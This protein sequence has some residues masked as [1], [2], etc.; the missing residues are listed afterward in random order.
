MPQPLFRAEVIEARRQRWLGPVVLD[1][2]PLL[3][4]L[5]ALVVAALLLGLGFAATADYSR[6]TR[7]AGVLV[8]DRGLV[9]VLAPAA[10]VVEGVEADEGDP[11]AAGRVLVRLAAP[12]ASDLA[13]DALSAADAGLDER[14]RAAREQQAAQEAL[15]QVRLDSVH[16]Q[17]AQITD[18]RMRLAAEH[19]ARAGQRAL[20][21]ESLARLE[22][23]ASSSGRKR[24][25][26]AVTREVAAFLQNTPAICRASYIAPCLYALF[27]RGKLGAM[28]VAI[29]ET[30]GLRQ[31]EARLSGVLAAAG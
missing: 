16:A 1:T 10:G 27:D 3:R 2:P 18:E 25:M 5:L 30:R 22:P 19:A 23:A 15:L 13:G 26:A 28:W 17:Q 7:A 8:P 21:A 11:V 12:A 29:T 14:M 20:A 24:Q 4:A 31:R 9:T 6:R